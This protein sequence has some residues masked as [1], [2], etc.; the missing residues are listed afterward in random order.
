[1]ILYDIILVYLYYIYII[2]YYISLVLHYISS[3]DVLKLQGP[4]GRCREVSCSPA[5]RV[6][7]L[8]RRRRGRSLLLLEAVR[9]S[10]RLEAL[11]VELETDVEDSKE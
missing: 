9:R 11:S 5:E 10:E 1:M 8:A 3:C 2:L 7:H 4:S 6:A